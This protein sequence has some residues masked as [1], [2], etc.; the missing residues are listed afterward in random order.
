MGAQWVGGGKC[1]VEKNVKWEKAG[2]RLFVI[3]YI[4]Y[5]IQSE[6]YMYCKKSANGNGG[7]RGRKV[8]SYAGPTS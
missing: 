8:S 3:E 6:E 1:T 5:R 7:G 2:Y 4:H